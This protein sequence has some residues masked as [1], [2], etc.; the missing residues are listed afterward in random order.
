M[1]SDTDVAQDGRRARSHP[2]PAQVCPEL[3]ATPVIGHALQIRREGVLGFL[4]RKRNQLGDVFRIRIGTHRMLVCSHP[5]AYERV[6]SSHKRNYIKGR[7]YDP[8][9]DLMGDSLITLEGEPWRNRRRL[10]QPYFHRAAL[11]KLFGTMVEVIDHYLLDL[12]KRFPGGGEVDITVEMVRLT[13]DVVCTALFGPGS[14]DNDSIS[15]EVLASSL[16][17]MEARTRHPFPLWMPTPTNLRF[18]RARKELDAVI[19]GVIVRARSSRAEDRDSTLLGMLLEIIDDGGRGLSDRNLRDELVSLYLAGHET[20][21]LTLTWMFALLHGHDDVMARLVQESHL[22]L[23][24]RLPSIDDLPD[25]AY[26]RRVISETLRLRTPGS[27]L[28]RS[29]VDKDNLC[30]YEVHPGETVM[31]FSWGLHHHSDYW[32]DPTR[33][34]PTRFEPEQISRRDPWAY[35]PFSGGPRMCIGNNFAMYEGQ[36]II[37]M[38]MQRARWSVVPG[39]TFIPKSLG[40]L[41]P[42]G[43]VRVAFEWR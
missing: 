39:Q 29:V 10:A 28:P 26:T 38:L 1:V 23:G 5:D 31:L 15:H 40:T 43:E 6:L 20:I 24:A 32:P 8:V 41:R 25:L 13:L 14:A 42:S 17:L 18:K 19:Y 35:L 34:D 33:F 9:R 27:Y 21:A 22:A 30:G 3:D 4:E 12:R 16:E 2:E 36:L 7:I 37:A 11:K